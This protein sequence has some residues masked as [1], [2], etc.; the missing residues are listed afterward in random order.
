MRRSRSSPRRVLLAL[1]LTLPLV[2]SGFSSLPSTSADSLSDALAR[3]RA[4]Q[5]Q[6]AAQKAALAALKASQV[7][8]TAA[9]ATTGDRL[10]SINTDQASVK[11]QIDVATQALQVVQGH[12]DELVAQLTHLDWTLGLL[13]DELTQ[14]QADLALRKGLLAQHLS[15][16][17]KLQRTSL[18]EQILASNS[19]TDVLAQVG[20]YLRVGDEDAALAKEIEAQRAD[21]ADLQ[22]TTEA[23]RSRTDQLRAEVAQELATLQAQQAALDAARKK[24]DKLE[25]RTLAIQQQQTA[26]F[27]K[28]AKSKAAA[29]ALLAK[30]LSDAAK[31]Q[32]QVDELVRQQI[33]K[34]GVP[35]EYKGSLIWP[36]SGYISQEFGCTGFVWEPPLGNCA[37]FHTGIDIV[38]ASGTPIHAAAPGVVVLVGYSPY[39]D[40]AWLVIIAHSSHLVTWYAHM[41]PIKPAGIYAGAV[42]TQGQ[43][44]GYE[45]CTGIC[46]GPH[47][48]WAV[49]LNKTWINPRLFL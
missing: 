11:A 21:L 40:G 25:T 46:T 13:Q 9:L 27:G 5:R 41:Q 38:R 31:L 3:Q 1:L 6:I 47:L 20:T 42:V 15:D 43:V 44:I 37:H 29:A 16:A 34:G 48:H 39:G 28:I 12:Y 17:Y 33:A 35:A 45:G 30:E 8:L 22:R 4:L 32:A 23:T 24:L 19:L 18:L 49:Q 2:F 26:A 36:M 10:D 7:Q 14:G